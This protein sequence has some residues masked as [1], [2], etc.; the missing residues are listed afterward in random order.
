MIDPN[1]I[2]ARKRPAIIHK[3]EETLESDLLDSKKQIVETDKRKYVVQEDWIRTVK[4]YVVVRE[5]DPDASYSDAIS[6]FT[7]D[8]DASTE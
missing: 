6:E 8:K 2:L 3:Y 4:H 7:E 1:E 5:F